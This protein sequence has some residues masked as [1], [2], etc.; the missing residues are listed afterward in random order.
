MGWS[1]EEAIDYLLKHTSLNRI[2]AELEID[3][4]PTL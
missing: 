4:N 3:R 2:T 1:K